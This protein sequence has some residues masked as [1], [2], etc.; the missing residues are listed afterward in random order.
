MDMETS[1]GSQTQ[2]FVS[3]LF[4][5]D[6]VVNCEICLEPFDALEKRPKLL[7]CGHN[8]CKNCLFSLCCHQQYYLLESVACPTCRE[9]FSTTIAM[10][11]PVNYDL[12]KMLESVQKGKEV[13]VIHI[14][15]E[16]VANVASDRKDATNV[17]LNLSRATTKISLKSVSRKYRKKSASSLPKT[18]LSSGE[19][20]TCTDC[21]RRFSERHCA[22]WVRFCEK[23]NGKSNKLVVTCLEC[24]VERH[25]GHKLISQQ[26]LE[27]NHHRL[28]NDL[29]ELLRARQEM[30]LSPSTLDSTFMRITKETLSEKL[31]DGL[32]QRIKKLEKARMPLPPAVIVKMRRKELRNHLK[33]QKINGMFEKTDVGD[34]T[35]ARKRQRVQ[36]LNNAKKSADHSVALMSIELATLAVTELTIG[37]FESLSASF[38]VILSTRS[39]DMDKVN[40]YLNCVRQLSAMIT[41]TLVSQTLHLLEDALL[42]CFLNLHLITKN[43]IVIEEERRRVWKAV[44]GT[45]TELLR[46][47]RS[48]WTPK[49]ASRVEIVEDIAY[50]CH[51]YADVCDNATMLICIIEAARARSEETHTQL[52]PQLKMIDEHL[53]ECRKCH[54]QQRSAKGSRRPRLFKGLRTWFK[55][56]L[57]K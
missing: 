16:N 1:E 48:I 23:C 14:N 29:Y 43:M 3:C 10:E 27:F 12:C 54:M 46:V 8:F 53:A 42:N 24:C 41:D 13:T 40:A 56:V 44:Q 28:I 35:T 37:S 6:D 51:M 38:Q 5:A 30:N 50:L 32:P 55:T 19:G 49:D 2:R 11:A 21:N 15:D 20:I 22:K 26:D 33:L 18:R 31:I 47:A 7:P 57:S 52:E 45:F 39:T 25:N 36:Q 9:E 17:S 4:D 34:L